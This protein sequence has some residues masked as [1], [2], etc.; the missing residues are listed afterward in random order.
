MSIR[1]LTPGTLV[2]ME[3][4]CILAASMSLAILVFTVEFQKM[5]PQ[6]E[7]M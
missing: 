3:M 1:E 6:A 2:E 7:T 5:L 4:F